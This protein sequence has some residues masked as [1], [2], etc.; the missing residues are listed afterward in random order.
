M[1]FV[2]ICKQQIIHTLRNL[3]FQPCL[4]LFYHPS[5]IR[6]SQRYPRI[7]CHFFSKNCKPNCFFLYLNLCL[8]FSFKTVLEKGLGQ[9]L[10][11]FIEQSTAVS[12]CKNP[13]NTFTIVNHSTVVNHSTI[14][15]WLSARSVVLLMGV[16]NQL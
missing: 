1:K 13:K 15:P 16:Q 4:A 10:C 11:S 3:C 14:V 2:K 6:I 12:L 9:N 5:L 7:I 8:L